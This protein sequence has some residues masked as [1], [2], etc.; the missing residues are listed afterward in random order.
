MPTTG[1]T[2][3]QLVAQVDAS[4]LPYRVLAE[5]ALGKPI[6]CVELGGDRQPPILITAGSHA[7]EWAGPLAALRLLAELQTEQHVYLIPCRDPLGLE[8]PCRTLGARTVG[9]RR[10]RGR[11]DLSA[12]LDACDEVVYD[13]KGVVIVTCGA[14]GAIVVDESQV[15]PFVVEQHLLPDLVPTR[16]DLIAALG[17]RYLL[18]VEEWRDGKYGWCGDPFDHPAQVLFVSR[19]GAV[20]NLNRFFDRDDAP[21]EVACVRDLLD[22]VQ[23]GLTLDLHE[24]FGDQFYL[25]VPLSDDPLQD[26]IARA[27]TQAVREQ[28][29]RLSRFEDLAPFWG[30]ALATSFRDLGDGIYSGV[31]MTN[32]I[33]LG[34]YARRHGASATTETG[35]DAP[36]EQRIDLLVHS[37]LAAVATYEAHQRSH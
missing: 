22:R 15:R 32:A 30:P 9:A 7:T 4:Q 33:S 11:G 17:G 26:R 6:L 37:V 25:I 18:F 36:I 13:G 24:G 2:G 8:G 3:D 14:L 12:W 19:S 35:M 31:H 34:S 28:G 10:L 1:L 5:T 16:P 23:P 27:M 20:G 29:G 21:P